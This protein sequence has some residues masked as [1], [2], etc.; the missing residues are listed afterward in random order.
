MAQITVYK[1]ADIT[2]E[3][4]DGDPPV[5]QT[6]LVASLQA[7]VAS[8]QADNALLVSQVAVLSAKIDAAKQ[9]LA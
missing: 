6:A 4:I 1:P 3:V 8:L 2:L 7:S 5:D 9:A